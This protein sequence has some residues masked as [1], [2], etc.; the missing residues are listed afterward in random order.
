MFNHRS[1]LPRIA[2]V[3][4]AQFLLLIGIVALAQAA[5]GHPALMPADPAP[6]WEALSAAGLSTA[7]NGVLQE[8]PTTLELAIVSSPWATLD[9]NKPTGTGV[10]VPKVFVVE[11]VITNT[12]GAAATG[13]EVSL[14][15]NE[16]PANNWVL[17]PG[18]DPVRGLDELAPGEAYHAYWFARY[19]LSF[20]ATHEYTVTAQADNAAPVVTS[21]NYYENPDGATVKTRSALSTGN[22]G[23]TQVSAD[24]TVGVAFT[25]TVDYDLGTNPV[26]A[27]LSPVGNVDFA[28]GAYRLLASQVR[29]YDEAGTNETSIADRLYF[30]SLPAFAENAEATYTFI[31]VALADTRVCPYTTVGYNSS[32]KYDQFYCN[33]SKFTIVPISGTLS[34]SMTKAVSSPTIEQLGLLTYTIRYT[35]EG[36]LP[37]SYVW[38]W[39]DVDPNVASVVADTISPAPDPDETTANRVAWYLDTVAAGATGTFTVTALVDGGGSDLADGTPVV[40]WASFGINQGSLPEVAALTSTV[41]TT[42]LA[43]D[44]AIAK[45]DG[46]DAVEPGEELTYTLRITNSGSIPAM[47]AIIT[48]ILSPE[49][50]YAPGAADPMPTDETG[51][52]LVWDNLGP[53]PPGGGSVVITVPVTVNSVVTNGTVLTNTGQVRY[54]NN[55]GWTFDI[56]SAEDTTVV[57]APVLSI[58][59]SAAPDPVLVG[60][61]LTYTLEYENSG[62]ASA[63]NVVVTDVVPADTTYVIASCSGGTSCTEAGGVVQW[64]LGTV[65]AGGGGSVTFAV[66]VDGSLE[67]GDLIQNDTYGI[68]AD[69]TGVIVGPPVTTEV[70]R[71]A[72]V[73]EGYTFIDNNG[74]GLY[75]GGDGPLDGIT[76]TLPESTQSPTTT[77]SSG[78]YRLRVEVPG[79]VSISA[80]LPDDYFR[81]TAGTVLTDSVLGLTQTVSFGYAPVTESFGVVYGTVY[82]DADHDGQRDVGENGL[83]EVEVSSAEATISP[84][85]TDAYGRYTLAY[86]TAG[87]ATIMESN[88]AGYVSTTPDAVATDVVMG[89]SDGSPIDFGDFFGIRVTGQVFVDADVDGVKDAG[90]AGL[91]GALVA[92]NGDSYTTAS[93]GPNT[94]VYTLYLGLNGTDAVT[95]EE[96]DPAGYVSTIALPGV[97]M[98][99]V[100]ANTLRILSPEAGNHY[101]D[102]DFGDVL[103]DSVVTISG[104]VWDDNGDLDGTLANGLR[105]GG[106][107]GLAG[108]VVSLSSG[109]TQTTAADGAFLLYGP[110]GQAI[111]VTETNPESYVSTNAIPG[112][113]ATK[114]D[115]DTLVAE[116]PDLVTTSSGNLFGDVAVDSAA[117][118]TGTVFD[119]ANENGV[120]DDGEIGLPKV[121]VTLEIE[122]DNTIV[123]YTD[124]TGEYQFAVAPAANVRLSSAGP[125]GSYYP[126]TPEALIVHPMLADTYP[127]NNFG[128]SDDTDVAVIYG[129][130]FED[131]NSNAEQDFGELGLGDAVVELEGYT[132]VTTVAGGPLAGTFVFTVTETSVYAVYETNPTGYRST[133]PDQLNVSV[134]AL[135]GSYFVPFGDVNDP[136]T[137]SIYG[138]VFDDLDGDGQQ[139]PSEPGLAGVVI[140]AT[141]GGEVGVVTATTKAYGQFT[142]GFEVATEGIHTVTEQD[143]ALPGYRSTTPD[144]IN[145]DVSL[146]QSYIVNFGDT[147]SGDFSSILG[148]VFHD[149]DGSGT[150][151]ASELG[152]EA[153]EIDLSNG[154]TA[155]TGT[156]GEYVF[157][158]DSSDYYQV[159]ETDPPG[160]HST[161]PNT[162]TVH[163]VGLGELYVVNFGDN[164]DVFSASLF[165]TVFEDSNVNGAR[166]PEEL[167]LAGA[168]VSI[169]GLLPSYVTN[170]WGQYTFLLEQAGI[171][172][173]T[174]T[175]L[176]GYVS[177]VALPG[178][179]A[180]TAVDANTLRAEVASLGTDLGDN[181]FGDVRASEAITISGSVWDDNGA[182]GGV[183]ANGLREA[184]EPGLAGA[185]V[186]LNSGLMATTG[187]DGA[188]LLYARPDQTITV[189][190]TNPDGYLSTGAIAGN[191]ATVL[192]DDHLQVNALAGGS[193]SDANLFGDVMPADLSVIKSDDPDPVTPGG[194]L[195]YT[196]TYANESTQWSQEVYVT[197]TL[198]LNTALGG[199]VSQPAGWS[200]LGDDPLTW[201]TPT[202]AGGASGSLVFTVTVSGEVTYGMHLTNS[203][204]I[205]GTMLDVAPG[206]NVFIET[207]RVGCSCLPD[208][209]EEDDEVGQASP[210]TADELQS[211]DFCDD[212]GDWMS[213]GAKAGQVITLTTSSWGRRADTFLAIYDTDGSTLLAAND[214]YE[215]TTDFSSN[216][217]WQVTVDGT[218]FV[219]VSNRAGLMGCLT[220]Y[221]L[222]LETSA[223]TEYRLYLP[224]VV[225]NASLE[226]VVEVVEDVVD[227]RGVIKHEC[228]DDYEVDDTWQD[229][230]PLDLGV[231]QVHSF[232][233]DPLLYAADKDFVSLD[234][235]AGERVRVQVTT[236][237]NTLTLLELYD[238]QGHLLDSTAET[239]LSWKPAEDAT[240]IVG[241]SPLTSTFGCA[242]DVGYRI[243][244]DIPE[245]MTIYLPLAT[246]NY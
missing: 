144:E 62:P 12:G 13:L 88:P 108:A 188:F 45:S 59:K 17:L 8:T 49:V 141:V 240:Y 68:R 173:V 44:V 52:A 203:V 86:D 35:N 136:D 6:N 137:A 115:H 213:F 220:D 167:G 104:W 58:S 1:T 23:V 138:T 22:S 223:Q 20:G 79:P 202:L 182:A 102:G 209:Y 41:T 201:Y 154:M 114:L 56:K 99:A 100:D 2:F 31:S 36:N 198:D 191:D 186:S 243:I 235:V 164:G 57:N 151:D 157:A 46:R 82:A 241:I 200:L 214:D 25:V 189:T 152:I 155:T 4:I 206:N 193:T 177:T 246:K 230:K 110:L 93:S 72:A 171:Y 90:E 67:T 132:P 190:E 147:Q 184:G 153:V 55:L 54:A 51:Q 87:S 73:F 125:G 10:E 170:D 150:Q 219:Q 163:V 181:L 76:I 113:D 75:D 53:I 194:V 222:W 107:P 71:D 128:Y 196:L 130:V 9:S 242:A 40:N 195:T 94:G 16:D 228:P 101:T 33:D 3:L 95:V 156:Y 133:T 34:L 30:P 199:M 48:D 207:T 124:A 27:H 109:L 70:N 208:D 192:D 39:D 37:L 96:T 28:A 204:H 180:V 38:I 160:Y 89:S 83:S 215:G 237:T 139:D 231:A 14:D 187:P 21:D 172:T 126:T 78:Y 140:S 98:E 91:G 179:A 211:H 197:D 105:D 148:I 168:E 29:F 185:V 121:T 145:L 162:V 74:N 169:G 11:A 134:T 5:A 131:L 217:V 229:A 117:I 43:P 122:E 143:P 221:D 226:P 120:Q 42:V 65:A 135:G 80:E 142:Y 212:A 50:S 158:V 97:D 127:N 61:A 7:W 64:D 92:G 236:L 47:S 63:T 149:Q 159:S 103:A 106:E 129:L 18:E 60:R 69:Q 123:V 118:I 239:Q 66:Q 32:R 175:D 178:D 183:S 112:N 224:L 165:G 15:Y 238:G 232:D 85:Q 166:E 84:V 227:P 234:L 218:Y 24:I 174:E 26:D 233:S 244:A 119:D 245:I 161:T 225:R 205:T 77:N 19:S 146:G 116:L 210:L 176:D 81:T 216:I 111:T